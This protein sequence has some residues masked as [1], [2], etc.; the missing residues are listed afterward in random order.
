MSINLDKD[1]EN[2]LHGICDLT[3]PKS[4]WT[5]EAH[6]AAAIAILSDSSFDA[7]RDMPRIIRSY[8][9]AEYSNLS[10]LKSPKLGCLMEQSIA[11]FLIEAG[12]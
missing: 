6:F 4:E 7:F 8:N 5:H 1:I 2:I 10:V 12:I 9:E 3:L 11:M